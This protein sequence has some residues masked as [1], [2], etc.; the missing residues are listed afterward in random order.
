VFTSPQKDSSNLWWPSLLKK[1]SLKHLDSILESIEESWLP[2]VS[3]VVSA[4]CQE[5]PWVGT[6]SREVTGLVTWRVGTAPVRLARSKTQTLL[7]TCS[8]RHKLQELMRTEML[9]TPAAF[10]CPRPYNLRG[11]VTV[12]TV[13]M[14]AM[15]SSSSTLSTRRP[16][17]TGRREC[18]KANCTN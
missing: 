17:E 6:R 10:N 18:S 1:I 11:M 9:G 14:Y 8:L 4:E 15:V 3:W 16:R 7:E 5:V 13:K 12:S 2:P